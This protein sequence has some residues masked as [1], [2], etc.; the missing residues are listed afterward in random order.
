MP[1]K[2][3]RPR[4]YA[5]PHPPTSPPPTNP[6]TLTLRHPPT[7]PGSANNPR[8]GETSRLG[9][10]GP[11]GADMLL[12]SI[13][14]MSTVEAAWAMYQAANDVAVGI[15]MGTNATTLWDA[16]ALAQ[17]V[18]SGELRGPAICSSVSYAPWTFVVNGMSGNRF[19]EHMKSE[20]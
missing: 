7:P 5:H 16:A 4:R 6:P 18:S 12:A 1:W 14:K 10:Y 15:A 9:P 8:Q 11:V 3:A 20:R 19:Y 13:T 17:H 2:A